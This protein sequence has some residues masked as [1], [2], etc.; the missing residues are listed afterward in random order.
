MRAL[1]ITLVIAA[2]VAFLPSE[3]GAAPARAGAGAGCGRPTRVHSFHVDAQWTK[4]VYRTSEKAVVNLT[5]TRPAHEDPFELGIPLVPPVS[6][7]QEGVTVTT[8]ILTDAWPPPFGYG[9]T[10][11][12]GQLTLRI[13]LTEVEPG[14]QVATHYAEMWTNE[15]GC[16][17][18]QEWGFT[19]Q[20]P[21]FKVIP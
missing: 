9:T 17:D 11:D 7:P 16:P 8:A 18:I 4:K 2:L 20:D 6:V 10:D 5:V 14:F 19:R 1:R 13:P 12:N 3:G 21:A 15:G